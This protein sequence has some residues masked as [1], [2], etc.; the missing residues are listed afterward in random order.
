[1]NIQT[2]IK[3]NGSR[4]NG[5]EP[6]TIDQLIDMLRCEAIEDRFFFK[7]K[8]RCD[9]DKF[10]WVVFCPI[11]KDGNNYRF[12]GNFERVS[13]VFDI[14]TNDPELIVRLKS[15]IMANGG[16]KR[17]LPILRTKAA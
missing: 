10:E 6:A 12:W 8:D 7:K 2:I 17:Y 9:S 15:A 11:S 3:S 5:E 1:M 14:I 4:W 16:W 13:H